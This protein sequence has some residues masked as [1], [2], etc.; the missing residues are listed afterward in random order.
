MSGVPKDYVN[1]LMKGSSS[2]EIINEDF[3]RCLDDVSLFSFY[4]TEPTG[5]TGISSGLI[6]DKASAVLGKI[7]PAMNGLIA[8]ISPKSIKA[9]GATL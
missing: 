1:D 4:E 2:T 5:I 6:V 7:R 9:R 8:D 3:I